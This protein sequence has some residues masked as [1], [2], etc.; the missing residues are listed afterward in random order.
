MFTS[1][2]KRLT[3]NF[4]LTAAIVI[5]I[6]TSFFTYQMINGIQNQMKDDGIT[7]ANNVRA[8]I[9][10]SGIED[11]DKI[12]DIIDATYKYASGELW[13]ISVIS[14]D[15]TLVA[16]TS[17]NSISGKVDASG[18]D[19][20][21]EGKTN[22]YM[23][24]WNGSTA[25]NVYVPIKDGNKVLYSLSIGISIENMKKSIE[26]TII[27]SIVCAILVLLLAA[28][29]GVFI[30]K[31]IGEPIEIIKDAIEKAGDGDFTAEYK[32]KSKD[33]I[34]KLAIASDKTRKN[35]RELVRKIKVISE[36][37]SN[38]SEQIGSSG[39]TVSLSSE[40][41]VTSVASVSEEGMKQTEA[42]KEAV[43]LLESFSIDLDNV[44]NNLNFLADGGKIIK[45]DT[46]RG[47][48]TINKLAN[49]IDEMLDSFLVSKAKVENLDK[50]ISQINSI[51]DVINGVAKQT[52]LLALNAS[53]EAAR[54]GE[55]GKGFSVVAEEIRKLAEEVLTSSKSIT[56][57]INTVMKE[58]NDV[59]A[60]TELVTKIVEESKNDINS[61]TTS[62]KG[63]ISKVNN[64]PSDINKVQLV[65][66][67]TMEGRNKILHTVENIA[68]KSQDI[69]AL[70]EDVTAATE[71]QAAITNELSITAK[72]LV[73]IS[74]VLGKNV[75]QFRT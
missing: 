68:L 12:Q 56:Q 62:F 39:N 18:L 32:I 40:D 49:T 52:N 37:L 47:A 19:S 71:E 44:D 63:V 6:C 55:A 60:T 45:E 21:F 11:V 43:N 7:L 74:A 69:S 50:T 25:Y 8:N 41:I 22:S 23:Y 57:L 54:A 34:G 17:K 1:I 10:S 5:L 59:S 75:S 48:E 46:N 58:T 65:L 13:Y 67:G 31:R 14:R 3:F 42:L 72:K 73:N 35:M 29:A 27:K 16:G 70:S 28:I 53:I 9:E 61:V 33:E 38:L 30:G 26:I 64:I 24:K 20:V 51:V 36:S 66:R 2:K 15:K 4:V